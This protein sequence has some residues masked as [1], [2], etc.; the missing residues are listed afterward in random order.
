ML[1]SRLES[2][3]LEVKK[4]LFTYKD[5][6]FELSYLANSPD[7]MIE[8][9][10]SM[11]FTKHII[12]NSTIFSQNLFVDGFMRYKLLEKGFW[13]IASHMK[14]KKDIS[15]RLLY[16]KRFPINYYTLTFH[17]SQTPF[18]DLLP[19]VGA[20]QRYENRFWSFFK[21]GASTADCYH[22]KGS[23]GFFLSFYFE[24][25]WIM[26]HLCLDENI[27]SF[28]ESDNQH[29]LIADISEKDYLYESLLATFAQPEK[30]EHEFDALDIKIKSLNVIQN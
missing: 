23:E 20:S 3:F 24:E 12:K 1:S 14:F 11:P 17:I 15:F 6:F 4:Y 8:H 19:Q 9:F 7:L 25:A 30:E 16:D 13:L 22:F 18:P 28:V 27:R 26:E 2:W 10:A 29:L 5:G 21:P